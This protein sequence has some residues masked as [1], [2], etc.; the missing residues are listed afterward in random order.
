MTEFLTN[1]INSIFTPG[2]TPTL[3][4]AT[5][6]SFAALQIVFLVLLILTY[7][8][9]FAILSLLSAGLWWS[10]NWFSHELDLAKQKEKEGELLREERSQ[11]E[12]NE[13]SADDSGS[14]TEGENIFSVPG[15][16][17]LQASLA[18]EGTEG[19][20]RKRRSIGSSAGELSTD[21]EWSQIEVEGI[22]LPDSALTPPQIRFLM[23]CANESVTIELKNGMN[24]ETSATCQPCVQG[25]S[26]LTQFAPTG[27]ILTGT[28]TSVS[29]QMNTALRAVKMTPKGRDTV[30]LDTIN[31][32]GSTI[33]FFILPDS[34]PL[35]TLLI[36]DAPKPK[37]K[38]RKE[39]ADK[40]GRGGRGGGRGRGRGGFRGGR[41]RGGGRGF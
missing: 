25:S 38:A 41:G 32:R 22:L 33:R 23:K 1:L 34:L 29:P 31:L 40:S 13:K 27:T 18:Q 9:H 19:A 36:D 16:P 35:D 14:E 21:S 4:V 26:L 37:N 39:Q 20:L 8:I 24:S 11:Q 15:R 7:S 12:E 30:T 2:P 6:V 17:N 28:V 10:I 3:I 5:N